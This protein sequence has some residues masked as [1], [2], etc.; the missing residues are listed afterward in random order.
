MI[1]EMRFWH[2]V[3]TVLYT[4]FIFEA[5]GSKIGDLA[6]IVYQ[7]YLKTD[8]KIVDDIESSY[9]MYWKSKEFAI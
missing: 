6:V 9:N 3:N 7:L 1:Y 4:E 8:F 2:D 5:F